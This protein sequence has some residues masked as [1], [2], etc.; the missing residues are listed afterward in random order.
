MGGPLLVSRYSLRSGEQGQNMVTCFL[1]TYILLY[2]TAHIQNTK[3]KPP[4]FPLKF[5]YLMEGA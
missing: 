4:L 3:L 1:I 2:S 5:V